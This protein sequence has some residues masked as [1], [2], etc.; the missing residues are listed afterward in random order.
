MSLTDNRLRR[1]DDPALS[2]EERVLMRCGI[3][4]DL[5]NTG[6]YEKA[7]AALG[8]YWRG[9]GVR[10][11]VEGL[12]DTIAAEVLLQCGALSGWL[13]TSKRVE[14]AQDAAKD[15]ISEARRI[16][17]AHSLRAR[18]AE[19]E[20]E[21]SICYWRAGALD[22]ARLI[23]QEALRK[24]DADDVETKAKI[25]IRSTLV[26]VSAGRYHDA[27]K[28]LDDAEPVFNLA[29]EVVRGK[30]HGQ[31]ALTLRRMGVA[32]GRSDYLDRAIIEFTAA[33]ISFERV[34]H[35]RYCGNAENNLAML[36][37]KLGRYEEAHE[38]LDKAQRIFTRLE[39]VGN[40][41]QVRETRARIFLAEG[42]YKKALDAIKSAVGALEKAGEPALLADALIVQAIAEAK[43]GQ[44]YLSLP[45]FKRAVKVAE[46]A[47]AH[48]CAGLAALSLLELLGAE[49]LTVDEAFAIY[50]RADDLLKATQD[51]DVI[52]RL[53]V[54]AR[55]IM[56]RFA[57]PKMGE[58]FSLQETM[59]SYEAKFVARALK[60]AGGSVVSAARILGITY[61]KMQY[62]LDTRH[63]ELTDARKPPKKRYKSI[64]KRWD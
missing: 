33:I 1:I 41:A 26:E 44:P 14:G 19:A 32:E 11:D 52:S 53:R 9:L 20:Y 49:L 22:E 21:L 4:S 48:E 54:C 23:L 51:A 8:E 27:L 60:R 7:R 61:Q 15:F 35:E 50:C 31:R 3:A 18:V 16:F 59:R 58:N 63:K 34:G 62:I 28:I 29:P 55:T 5:I 30:W 56:R 24:L 47:G 64:V 42:K 43:M 25:L 45:T 57:E 39:D 2:D 12:E 13:G 38:H 6:C 36:L 37:H 40:L 10:P 17:D 46:T